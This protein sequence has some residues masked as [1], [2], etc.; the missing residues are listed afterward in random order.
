MSYYYRM[1][2]QLRE[3]EEKKK[4][5]QENKI[6]NMLIEL[7]ELKNKLDKYEEKFQNMYNSLIEA[8]KIIS[9]LDEKIN[10]C[11]KKIELHIQ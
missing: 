3:N 7:E 10:H 4:I 6:N 5:D 9:K 2:L 11:P 8:T 1:T